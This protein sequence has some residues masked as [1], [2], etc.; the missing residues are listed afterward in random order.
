MIYQFEFSLDTSPMKEYALSLTEGREVSNVGGF[1]SQKHLTPPAVCEKLFTEV[2]RNL[3][4]EMVLSTLW[5][6]VNG[7][8]HYNLRHN[9]VDKKIHMV[10]QRGSWIPITHERGVSGV[11]YVDV[12]DDNMGDIVFD[13]RR[14][15]PKTNTLLL[16]SNDVAHA[17]EPNQSDMNRISIAFNYGDRV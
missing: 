13:D 16:F 6:N 3:S 15:T 5:F 10:N 2:E 4:R 12:P 1:Q 9:H 11:Y 17:V 7:K 14:V 8:G